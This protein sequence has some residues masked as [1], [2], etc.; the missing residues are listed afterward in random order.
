MAQMP[1]VDAIPNYFVNLQRWLPIMKSY[2]ARQP[3]Y[4]ATPAV[5]LI[6]QLI[7]QRI[8]L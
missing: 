5:Q 8:S 4:F 3:S 6:G 7:V 2:E 1:A